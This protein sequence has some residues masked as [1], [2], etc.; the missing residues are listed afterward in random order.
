MHHS[1]NLF[2]KSYASS[3]TESSENTENLGLGVVPGVI[4][5]VLP[6]LIS[7]QLTLLFFLFICRIWVSY[8]SIFRSDETCID[9][10]RTFLGKLT[11]RGCC[12]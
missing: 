11:G 4:V 7:L 8:G 9:D 12:S 6:P 3:L 2:G 5:G 10:T 1:V